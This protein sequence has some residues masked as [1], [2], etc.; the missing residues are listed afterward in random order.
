MNP[1]EKTFEQVK[2]MASDVRRRWPSD[3]DV[4]KAHKAFA[5]Y[6]MGFNRLINVTVRVEVLKLLDKLFGVGERHIR[7]AETVRRAGQEAAALEK[8]VKSGWWSLE[9]VEH[10][11]IRGV[12]ADALE[13]VWKLAPQMERD[14][15]LRRIGGEDSNKIDM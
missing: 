2:A 9:A 10:I 13:R 5:A 12:N 6:E 1:V 11:V 15:F 8:F 3:N 4:D 7:R 14:E